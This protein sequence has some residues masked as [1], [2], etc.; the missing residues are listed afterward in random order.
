MDTLTASE[1]SERMS[2]IK[3]K[4]TGTELRVR[5]LVHRLGYRYRLHDHRLPGKPDMVFRSRRKTIFV[6]GC[7]WHRHPDPECKL[8]RMPKS[9]LDFWEPKLTTNR[10]RDE[11]SLERLRDLGWDPLIVWECESRHIEQLE[12]KIRAFLDD[13]EGA[14]HASH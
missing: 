5:R 3:A 13:E 8:A 1:R 12:N 11:R 14:R 2:R 10:E 4:D 7:F 9:R 6:H